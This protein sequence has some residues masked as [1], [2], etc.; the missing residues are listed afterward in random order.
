MS[1]IDIKVQQAVRLI[2]EKGA[3]SIEIR[4]L[5]QYKSGRTTVAATIKNQLEAA[6]H[7][8]TLIDEDL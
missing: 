8:V 2:P 5:G 7:T 4:V 3:A 6:G 1:K